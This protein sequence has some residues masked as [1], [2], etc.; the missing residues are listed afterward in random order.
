MLLVKAELLVNTCNSA[1]V[2]VL[3]VVCDIIVK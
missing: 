1:Y 2:T 3:V